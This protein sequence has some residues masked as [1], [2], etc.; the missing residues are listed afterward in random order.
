VQY[1]DEGVPVHVVKAYRQRNSVAPLI[2]GGIEAMAIL[3]PREI[4]LVPTE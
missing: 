3:P 1:I 2:A 4:I